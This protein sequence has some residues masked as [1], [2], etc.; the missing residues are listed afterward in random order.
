MMPTQEDAS[1]PLTPDRLIADP[2]RWWRQ[3]MPGYLDWTPVNCFPRSL[4]LDADATPW[5]APPQ[6][7]SLAE[8]ANG[9]LPEDYHDLLEDLIDEAAASGEPAGPH[10]RFFR[11]ASP[12]LSFPLDHLRRHPVSVINMHPEHP[13]L[14]FPLPAPPEFKLVFEGDRVH[15]E[16]EVRSVEILPDD[17][18]VS[19]TYSASMPAPRLFM[20]GIHA[21]IPF[22]VGI[23]DR[24]PVRFEAP[25]PLK[26]QLARAQGHD[27]D[28]TVPFRESDETLPFRNTTRPAPDRFS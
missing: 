25:E 28:E 18:L 4:F 20:P 14:T 27:A 13:V 26:M 2:Q 22:G 3:P 15:L 9:H 6:D 1:D 11:E 5:F 23:D 24:E 12:G 17:L 8:V 7:R 19:L 21:K 16:P 10:W